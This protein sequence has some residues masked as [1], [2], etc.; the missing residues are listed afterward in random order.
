M[1][2]KMTLLFVA[3]CVLGAH[4]PRYPP[5][6]AEVGQFGTQVF[7]HLVADDGDVAAVSAAGE[8]AL[9]EISP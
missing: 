1:R 5:I 2:S 9:G 4:R 7:P 8:D 6:P 3:L